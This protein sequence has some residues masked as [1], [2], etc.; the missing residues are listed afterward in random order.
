MLSEDAQYSGQKAEE[1]PHDVEKGGGFE[2]EYR[3]AGLLVVRVAEA[4]L[5]TAVRHERGQSPEAGRPPPN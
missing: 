2:D 3:G 4:A 5:G 1:F